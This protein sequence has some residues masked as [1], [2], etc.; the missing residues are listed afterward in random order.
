MIFPYNPDL[1]RVAYVVNGES[2]QAHD[3]SR[4]AS[5]SP[6]CSS[7]EEAAAFALS[8]GI[9]RF[10]AATKGRLHVSTERELT[11]AYLRL[12]NNPSVTRDDLGFGFVATSSAACD[13]QTVYAR[14]LPEPMRS[15][16]IEHGRNEDAPPLYVDSGI[17]WLVQY[18]DNVP[19]HWLRVID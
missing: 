7:K 11:E 6:V 12:A 18:N 3:P 4:Y 15:A 9:T 17:T 1:H 16:A 8:R 19:P 2:W 10:K 14:D 5:L 13:L